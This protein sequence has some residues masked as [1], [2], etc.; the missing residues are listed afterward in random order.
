LKNQ[1]FIECKIRAALKYHGGK[2][3]LARRIL[4][5]IQDHSIYIEPFAGGLNVLLNKYRASLEVASDLNEGLIN[6]YKQLVNRTDEVIERVRVTPRTKEVFLLARDSVGV[7]DPLDRAVNFLLRH[8]LSRGGMGHDF[9]DSYD[10]DMY[11]AWFNL[12]DDLKLTA[13]RL[14][15]VDLRLQSA[16]EVIQEYDQTE[17]CLYCDPPY[18]PGSRISPKIYDHELTSFEHIK[19]L[20]LLKSFRGQVILS[21]YGNFLYDSELKDWQRYEYTSANHS[22]QQKIKP[23]VTEVIWVKPRWSF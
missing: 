19:L 11:Q 5:L 13:D 16:F 12:P 1:N 14:R 22:S 21:G 8:R 6:L 17:S 10:Q 23:K 9:S 7:T 15:G 3:H 2:S 4:G 18:Y 20:R